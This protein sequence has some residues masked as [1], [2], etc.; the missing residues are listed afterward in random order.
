MKGWL[1]FPQK[2]QISSWF[3]KNISCNV[4]H[5]GKN[6]AQRQTLHK[7]KY[8]V[9]SNIAKKKH[10]A[11]SNIAKKYRATSNIAKKNIAQHLPGGKE[12]RVNA[13]WNPTPPIKY[14]TVYRMSYVIPVSY[15]RTI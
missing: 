5:W 11:T 1:K 13:E 6:I 12:N 7:K 2:Y 9:T 10:R 3:F 4:K 14:Q 15:G 8:R